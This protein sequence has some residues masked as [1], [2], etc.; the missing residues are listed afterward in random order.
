MFRFESAL[1]IKLSF[2]KYEI[3]LCIFDF[4]V[5]RANPHWDFGGERVLR[6]LERKDHLWN[7]SPAGPVYHKTTSPTRFPIQIHQLL[8]AGVEQTR[9]QC[10]YAKSD[11]PII[12]QARAI[13]Y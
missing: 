4:P 12:D 8:W 6:L 11:F 3:N 2:A 13:T 9:D 1:R 10:F 7:S 5:I